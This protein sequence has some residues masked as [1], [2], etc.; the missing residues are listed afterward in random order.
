MT[1]LKESIRTPRPART[2]KSSSKGQQ[3][4]ER[5]DPRAPARRDCDRKAGREVQ[6]QETV[7]DTRARGRIAA[8]FISRFLTGPFKNKRAGRR[9]CRILRRKLWMLLGRTCGYRTE[10]PIDLNYWKITRDTD[11]TR[12]VGIKRVPPQPGPVVERDGVIPQLR[13]CKCALPYHAELCRP[14]TPC[15]CTR[16]SCQLLVSV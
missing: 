6:R 14:E 15:Q 3:V 13:F 12:H 11:S 7:F 2:R 4:R 8:A 10:R 5:A 1:R 9:A 16:R